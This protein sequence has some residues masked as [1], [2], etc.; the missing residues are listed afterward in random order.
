MSPPEMK[1]EH[2]DRDILQLPLGSLGTLWQVYRCSVHCYADSQNAEFL[3]RMNL[4]YQVCP[5]EA[6]PESFEQ[7]I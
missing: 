4:L 5:I 3:I 1:P 2:D 7:N 6:E